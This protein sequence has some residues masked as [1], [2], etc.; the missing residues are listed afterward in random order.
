MTRTLPDFESPPLTEVALSVQFEPLEKL[1]T[2]QVGALWTV[3]RAQFP[4]TEDHNPLAP[5]FERFGMPTTSAAEVRLEMLETPPLPRVW[6]LNPEGTE[7]IQVQ[8]DRFIHNWRKV[9][10]GDTYPRYE[11]VR[12]KFESEMTTF[13][14]V[15]ARE[16]IGRVV[17]NQ[18]EVTYVNHIVAGDGWQTHS[19]LANVVT[20]FRTAYIDDKLQEPEDA[21]LSVRYVLKDVK[22]AS[23]GRLHIS[24]QPA[25]RRPDSRPMLVLT[26]VA[27]LRPPGDELE[28]VIRALDLGRDAIVRAFASVTTP[29]MHKL[30]RRKDVE[31]S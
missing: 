18:C 2:A 11:H 1:R 4:R 28:H 17:A 3:F 26:L 24:A 29:E 31:R 14:D 8:Q 9:G 5:V 19:Q 6:F 25:F 21:G 23:L 30:W 27:R 15:L 10:Q 16:Q 20:V 13:Q 22:G 12:D 7:L